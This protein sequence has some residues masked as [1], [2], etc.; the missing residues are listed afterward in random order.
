MDGRIRLQRGEMSVTVLEPGKVHD[1]TRFSWDLMVE[2]LAW[3]GH[4]FGTTEMVPGEEGATT[5]GRGLMHEFSAHATLGKVEKGKTFPKI[6][7]GSLLSDQEGD[8]AFYHRYPIAE[9]CQYSMEHGADWMETQ[10]VQP[11]CQGYAMTLKRRLTVNSDGI[12]IQ[13]Q[14]T[15]TGKK[16]LDTT[17]YNH[18]FLNIDNIP[19]GPGYSLWLNHYQFEKTPEIMK[20]ENNRLVFTRKPT[21]PF[22]G[23][24]GYMGEGN[25]HWEM[26]AGGL[27]IREIGQGPVIRCVLWGKSNVFSAE[28]YV[29]VQAKVG[30]TCHWCRGWQFFAE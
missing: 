18:N 21:A 12:M 29:P 24:L 6:G 1:W 25:V 26:R 10:C 2:Q 7:I 16:D 8:Y 14:L 30:E 23:F 4:T 3:K 20:T 22:Y 5:D 13:S 28:C 17:E 27:G 15:N 11:L 19:V 9:P